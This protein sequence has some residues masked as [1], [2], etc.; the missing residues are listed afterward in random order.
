M[1]PIAFASA[2]AAVVASVPAG[3]LGPNARRLTDVRSGISVEASSGWTLS[4]RV[5]YAGTIAL[6]VHPDGSRISVTATTTVAPDADALYKQNRPG[7]VAQ[8]LIPSPS[9]PGARGSVSVDLAVVGRTDRMR[10]LYL[11][12]DIP[13]GRQAIV[14][15]LV[16]NVKS[17]AARAPALDFVATRL[18]LE[19]P[20]PPSGANRAQGVGLTGTGGVSVR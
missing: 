14:L 9:A 1:I 3:A 6:F 10:Q 15:T 7:L 17:F 20:P 2:V 5:G 12:R 16:S 8:G 18:T 11:V 19:D 4:Q 13:G